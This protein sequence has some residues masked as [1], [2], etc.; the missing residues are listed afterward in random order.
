MVMA[1]ELLFDFHCTVECQ[2]DLYRYFSPRLQV[3]RIEV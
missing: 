3:Y 2:A 1:Y